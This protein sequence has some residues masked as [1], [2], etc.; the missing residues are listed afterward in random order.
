MK[1]FA[2]YMLSILFIGATISCDD[3]DEELF[4]TS[5]SS[6]LKFTSTP[7]ASYLLTFETRMNTA[8]R[9]TWQPITYSTPVAVTYKLQA[10]AA[11]GDFENAELVG[12]TSSNEI[13]LTVEE[14][15]DLTTALGLV[16]FEQ[17]VINLRLE[18]S[19]ADSS[20]PTT[21]S[22]VINLIVTPY[23]TAVPKLYVPGNFSEASGY[24][25]NYA[26]GDAN[27]PFLEAVEFG[28]TEYEGFVFMNVASPSFKF[29]PEPVYDVAYGGD[30]TSLS[31]SGGDLSLPGAGYYFMTVNLDPNGDG[32]FDD[33]TWSAS[34]RSWG[35]IGAATEP[36][37]APGWGDEL[38]MTY[39]KDTKLWTVELNMQA[40]DFKFRAQ[41]WD[42]ATYNFG[43]KTGG[44]PN[45]LS[46]GGGN[47]SVAAGGRYRAE[48]DL[49][50]P[51]N[52]TYS[53][54]SI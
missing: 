33:A 51:R 54:T 19:I 39:N 10:V 5:P 4:T 40:E 25:A 34:A 32:N 46:F 48:L 38:D 7:A 11:G 20:Q 17:S 3:N 44:Q 15:N 45:E 27:T 52:Y 18:A 22:D 41:Q 2:F 37:N 35:I 24:G 42:P 50:Q 28:S 49:S 43:L 9:F 23:T 16:P 6:D 29:T 1:K 26:P 13:K 12:S 53:L 8:E 47:L 14:L 30:S 21:V 31:T 36:T